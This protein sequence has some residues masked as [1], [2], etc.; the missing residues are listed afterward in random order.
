M[1]KGIAQINFVSNELFW[2][3]FPLTEFVSNKFVLN[4][5]PPMDFSIEFPSQSNLHNA[6]Q[7]NFSFDSWFLRLFG[8]GLWLSVLVC[9][10]GLLFTRRGFP[11][12]VFGALSAAWESPLLE[13]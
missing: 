3:K 10:E 4:E 12:S 7:S 1:N 13:R 9:L 5:F 6:S 8:R 2:N 11:L